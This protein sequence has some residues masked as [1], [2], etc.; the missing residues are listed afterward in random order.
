[1]YTLYTMPGSCSTAI[2]ILLNKLNVPVDIVMHNDVENYTDINPTGQVPA[3]KTD[4][5]V[6]T[7]GAAIYLYL[8]E[9]H[10][11]KVDYPEQDF[12]QKLM[13]NYAT[14]HPAYAKMF[15]TLFG[16]PDS[17]EKTN[18]IA[19]LAQKTASI[20]QILDLHLANNKY[21]AGDQISIL[22]YLITVYVGWGNV[23]PQV[24]IPIGQNVLRVV[25]EVSQLPEFTTAFEKESMSFAIPNGAE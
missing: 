21:I 25:K 19:F 10:D 1:M 5:G 15:A 18:Y 12:M 14:L 7:E 22:D 13:F 24:A 17:E 8:A 4:N 16:M 23:F 20:W 3:L 9:K 2:H 6:L 11:I